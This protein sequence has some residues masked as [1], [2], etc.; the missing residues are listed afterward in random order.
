MTHKHYNP[1][2]EPLPN[3]T[4]PH[5]GSELDEDTVSGK[6]SEKIHREVFGNLNDKELYEDIFNPQTFEETC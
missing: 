4:F 6:T 1:L 3:Q 5:L 2:F